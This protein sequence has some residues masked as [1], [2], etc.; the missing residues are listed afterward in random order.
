MDRCLAPGRPAI[1]RW[2]L[3][4]LVVLGVLALSC[5]VWGI[6]Q[7]FVRPPDYAEGCVLFNAARIRSGLPLYVNP[8]V[9]AHEYGE[10]P[11][12]YFVAYTPLAA[13]WLSALPSEWALGIG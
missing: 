10:P 5:L 13:M 12:R 9:G 6:A 1:A 8:V 2:A 11:A 3:G 7:A 4:L